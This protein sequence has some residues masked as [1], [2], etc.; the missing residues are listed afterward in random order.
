M[1]EETERAGSEGEGNM[2]V[3]ENYR[4]DKAQVE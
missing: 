2:L 1:R 3:G 4:K